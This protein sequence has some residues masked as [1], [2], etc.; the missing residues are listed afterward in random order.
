MR[1]RDRKR[2]I[3]LYIGLRE[4][5][6]KHDRTRT[7]SLTHTDS[8]TKRRLR[9]ASLCLATAQDRLQLSANALGDIDP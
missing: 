8:V 1:E 7:Y 3:L 9:I 4:E 6:Q 2:E 5:T